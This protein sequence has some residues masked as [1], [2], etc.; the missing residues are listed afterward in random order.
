MAPVMPDNYKH[1][2]T[3]KQHAKTV[4]DA[5]I[6]QTTDFSVARGNDHPHIAHGL[7]ISPN[8]FAV[9][10][11]EPALGR[12]FRPEEAQTGR[13]GE[14]ILTWAAWQRYLHG[15]PAAIGK[16]LRISGSPEILVGVLPQ[17][18][19]MPALSVT[20][21][22]VPSGSTD[23]DEIFKPLVPTPD[24]L[25]EDVGEFNYVVVARLRPGVS[26]R[27]AQS[28]L[29]GLEKAAAPPNRV[30]VHLGVV[31][32]PLSQE[33]TG[34]VSQALWLLLAAV[35]GVLLIACVNLANLQLA[36]AL[37]RDRE[38]AIR[39]AL[40]ASRGRLLQCVLGESLLLALG[41]ALGGILLALAGV[42][43]FLLV[44]P[45]N[46][47]RLNEVHVSWLMLLVALGLSFGTT[48]FFGL[49]PALHAVRVDPQQALQSNLTRISGNQQATHTRRLLVAAEIAASVVL[50][51]LTGL[52][53]AQFFARASAR[54]APSMQHKSRWCRRT[55]THPHT[56]IASLCRTF[57]AS[58]PAA[59]RV[60]G[61]STDRSRS[62]ALC[63]ACSP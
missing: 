42:R 26:V 31:V 20:K 46:L 25:T 21:S 37:A 11:I 8:L 4:V 45:Q 34:R 48:L 57:P 41:G 3:L 56:G 23:R 39:S 55:Y 54:I 6:L 27:Q 51:V 29:D 63:P 7:R 47:P 9:L 60:R 44:A 33:T 40:G 52:F 28:E 53:R 22:A 2:L 5:A 15:N 19:R 36:R 17:G 14:V 1:Y 38:I 58:T 24:E 35:S 62:Y 16:P 13:D 59:T 12:G 18:F 43:V 61:L 30:G 10:G 49:L 32:Q 50:L